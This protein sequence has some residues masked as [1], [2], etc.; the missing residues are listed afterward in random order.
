MTLMGIFM[1]IAIPF[2]GK[3]ISR[4]NIKVILTVALSLA[5]QQ[6]QPCPYI[7]Q[8]GNGMYLELLLEYAV[9]LP[10]AVTVPIVIGNWF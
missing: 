4:F 1:T 3:A 5:F 6:L 2:A 9:V 7:M 8:F 10:I